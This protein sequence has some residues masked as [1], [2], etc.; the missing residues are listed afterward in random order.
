MVISKVFS[1]PRWNSKHNLQGA[2]RSIS[3]PHSNPPGHQFIHKPSPGSQSFTH[4]AIRRPVVKIPQPISPFSDPRWN[5][6]HAHYTD[7]GTRHRPPH[8]SQSTTC[9]PDNS[10]LPSPQS[11]DVPPQTPL[12]WFDRIP[13]SVMLRWKVETFPWGV[14]SAARTEKSS[15]IAWP[16]QSCPRRSRLKCGSQRFHARI[17][18]CSCCELLGGNKVG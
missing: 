12:W 16:S 11:P 2:A 15:S 18:E 6:S 1:G 4:P 3:I 7:G 10:S 8:K 9:A 13:I 5:N 17:L 14:K